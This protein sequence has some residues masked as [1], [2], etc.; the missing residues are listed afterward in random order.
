MYNDRSLFT[1]HSP[2]GLFESLDLSQ[3]AEDKTALSIEGLNLHYGQTQ[4]LFNINMRIAKG[5]V[6]AFIGPSGCGKSTLLSC[7]NR[8]NDLIDGCHIDGKVMLHGQ[9]VYDKNVD[10]AALRRQIGMV[11]QR[12][13]PFP[14]SIY[15][16]V[17]YG[18]RLQGINDRRVL[19]D[20]VENSLRSAALWNEVKGRLHE[21]AFGL[22]GG[23]QQR[24]VIARAIAIEPEILLL[25]E[26][27]SALDP[28]STLTIEE[29][30]N[31]LKAKYT[32]IIVTHNMQQAARVSDQT[33]FMHMGELVEYTSTNDIFTT[34]KEKRTE[35]Y[36]TG[37][38]G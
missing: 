1:D 30:I 3:L 18:L 33:A 7:I 2:I 22:S 37:R 35:D 28:I 17:V 23:Q 4:A 38:Y 15:E 34:P 5:Q 32:V 27:T 25:D 26:P 9:N 6:T 14:K 13:N 19:D 24:L 36:I 12:P 29:L 10:V 11:F 16:N 21:N 31:D 8:M 20:A